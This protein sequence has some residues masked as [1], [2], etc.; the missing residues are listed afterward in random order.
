MIEL[1]VSLLRIWHTQ[2]HSVVC[3]DSTKWF[4]PLGGH[5]LEC[6]ARLRREEAP[7]GL[8]VWVSCFLLQWSHDPA[9][10]SLHHAHTA[11]MLRG[12]VGPGTG[13]RI[14]A[15]QQGVGSALALQFPSAKKI[16]P[17]KVP[18]SQNIKTGEW[19]EAPYTGSNSNLQ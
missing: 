8:R 3:G 6:E 2:Y 5:R 12:G 15:E 19:T 16:H 11:L 14:L 1:Q 17:G 18:S 10:Y 4:S 13:P 7:L 9:L